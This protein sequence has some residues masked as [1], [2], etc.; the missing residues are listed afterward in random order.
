[1]ARRPLL[2]ALVSALVSADLET[3][4]IEWERAHRDLAAV[5]VDDPGRELGTWAQVE[6]IADELRRRLG[7]NFT[8]RE[9]ADEYASADAWARH[10]LAEQG[11]PGWPRTLSLV[12]GAAFHVYAR[13]AV[14]YS[15]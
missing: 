11:A 6:A 3:T 8:L 15:P 2:F 14:D 12:E 1:M 7:G 10:I 13:G 4:R 9:L 5:A